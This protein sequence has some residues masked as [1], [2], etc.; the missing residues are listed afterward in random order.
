MWISSPDYLLT[1]SPNPA[2]TFS[3]MWITA[4]KRRAEKDGYSNVGA[5]V[6]YHQMGEEPACVDSDVTCNSLYSVT[7]PRF[8]PALELC[9]DQVC[10]Q[11][12]SLKF[13]LWPQHHIQSDYYQNH[14]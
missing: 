6:W 13:T 7:S 1:R 10:G 4:K 14:T 12:F 11:A 9:F 5:T 8:S 2:T 3:Q